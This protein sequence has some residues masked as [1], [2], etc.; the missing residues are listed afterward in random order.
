MQMPNRGVQGPN[1]GLTRVSQGSSKGQTSRAI[2][3]NQEPNKRGVKGPRAKQGPNKLTMEWA[4]QGAAH[5]TAKQRSA[6]A[7]QGLNKGLT[8]AKLA[9]P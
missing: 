6:R 8:R 2:R 1:K 5:A 7:K 9:G 3:A 4:K